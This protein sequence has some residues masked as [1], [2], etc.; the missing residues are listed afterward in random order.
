MSHTTLKPEVVEGVFQNR[1]SQQDFILVDKSCLG[2]N[3]FMIIEILSR[4]WCK[5]KLLTEP[6]YI[7]VVK[8]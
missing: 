7:E 4:K 6:V 1:K 8:L 3:V 5:Q 2:T